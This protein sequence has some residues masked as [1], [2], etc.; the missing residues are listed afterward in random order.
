MG[1][2]IK[3]VTELVEAE[4]SQKLGA[5]GA[6]MTADV[7]AVVADAMEL[8]RAKSKE[9]FHVDKQSSPQVHEVPELEHT[10]QA[11][12]TQRTPKSSTVQL[13]LGARLLQC[14]PMF[15]ISILWGSGA[16][17]LGEDQDY[18]TLPVWIGL[19][20]IG[21]EVWGLFYELYRKFRLHKPLRT[22]DMMNYVGAG[23]LYLCDSVSHQT[24]ISHAWRFLP[25]I[26]VFP[27]IGALRMFL[28]LRGQVWTAHNCTK[29]LVNYATIR[30]L[31]WSG[32]FRPGIVYAFPVVPVL[33]FVEL[34][35][36]NLLFV[37]KNRRKQL[38]TDYLA[39]V[40]DLRAKH[41][42]TLNKSLS[43]MR[44]KMLGP[45]NSQ[46]SSDHGPGII[47]V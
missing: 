25:L 9:Q 39:L 6:N 13:D 4:L 21:G 41:V 22:Y 14:L 19:V 36:C 5:I 32:F 17:A 26:Y 1:N 33:V 42:R 2:K 8:V 30:A 43:K 23:S 47:S 12:K 20:G 27:L 38:D 46:L 29:L 16:L 7:K 15:V 18:A 10:D 40:D 44:T 3:T 37:E 28:I 34:R 35:W 31:L 11:S 24:Q 45:G